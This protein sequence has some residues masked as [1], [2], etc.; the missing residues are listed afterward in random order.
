M[1]IHTHNCNKL[2]HSLR[3]LGNEYTP[4]PTSNPLSFHL[5]SHTVVFG[6]L[7]GFHDL[8]IISLY[9]QFP[10]PHSKKIVPTPFLSIAK[11]S[12]SGTILLGD[13]LSAAN[14]RTSGLALVKSQA[15]SEVHV[16]VPKGDNNGTKRLRKIS[17]IS[18]ATGKS[19]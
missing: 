1:I 13:I 14:E 11:G 3:V 10:L 12:G 2:L 18:W 15:N 6:H 9:L 7:S 16:Q 4:H 5:S 19:F 17:K 8:H